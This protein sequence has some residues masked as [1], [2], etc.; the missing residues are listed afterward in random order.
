M[1]L[2]SFNTYV[3]NLKKDKQKW[4]K[5]QSN[6]K[7]TGIKLIRFNAIHGAN[8]TDDDKIFKKNHITKKCDLICT[9]SMIGCGLSHIKLA[10]NIIN[11]DKNDYSLILEDDVNPIVSNFKNEIIKAINNAPKNADMIKIYY[12][13]ACKNPNDP[14]LICGSTAG[15]IITKKGA[16]KLSNFQLDFH[17]DWQM[18]QTPNF[19][20]YT[21]PKILISTNIEDSNIAENNILNKVDNINVK[22]FQKISWYLN[23]PLFKIPYFNINITVIKILIFI[24][25]ITFI[26]F[27]LKGIIMLTCLVIFMF[28]VVYLNR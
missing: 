28:I 1:K 20:V 15:Y 7:N 13:G 11:N 6:F 2:N 18:Q 14:F 17:I 3:I 10:N 9:D 24:Y 27:K 16:E 23:E 12:H 19:I 4:K 25:I 26:F 5:M 22:G 8:L 21:N